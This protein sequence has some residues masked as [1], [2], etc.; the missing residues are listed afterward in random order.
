M[1]IILIVV[2]SPICWYI[3]ELLFAKKNIDSEKAS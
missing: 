2:W 3:L 1:N